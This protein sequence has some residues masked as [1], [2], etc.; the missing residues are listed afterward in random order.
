LVDDHDRLG[1]LKA[2]ALATGARYSIARAAI[3]EYLVLRQAYRSRF[4]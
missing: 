1:R 3:S 4:A 2:G